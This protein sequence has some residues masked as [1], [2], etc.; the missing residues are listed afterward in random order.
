[1]YFNQDNF[2]KDQEIISK[3]FLSGLKTNKM[4]QA[5]LLYGDQYA[6]LFQVAIYLAKSLQCENKGLA[7]NICPSCL[8]FEKGVHPDLII[9]DGKQDV[10]KKKDIDE[11]ESF[12][13]LTSTEKD[14]KSVYIINQIE[15]ITEEALN[16][17]LKFLEEPNGQIL[18]ILTT[19]NRM[20]VLPTILSRCQIL[21][22]N[23]LDINNLLENYNGDISL[24]R[25][26]ILSHLL[27]SEEDKEIENETKEFDLAFN[28]VVEYME[29]YLNNSKGK[30]LVLYTQGYDKIKNAKK[31]GFSNNK[32]Y[33]YF[34]NTMCIILKDGIENNKSPFSKY[35][36]LIINNKENVIK[37]I[38]FLEDM[39]I[40]QASNLNFALI[41]AK[42]ILIMEEK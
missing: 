6:P 7:C 9:L 37:A 32:C 38:K 4:S 24:D 41:L 14:H 31:S 36:Q 16:A 29:A 20:R 19:N 23:A 5:I 18:A 8:R 17:L 42:F 35:N 25:Y 12:F 40:K 33:N 21:K 10:I 22:V 27:F 1:M 15:N 13:A 39:V 28:M 34:Y 2:K 3:W 11:L 30:N 26:Y